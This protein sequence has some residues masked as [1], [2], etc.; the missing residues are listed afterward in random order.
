[1]VPRAKKV[2]RKPGAGPLTSDIRSQPVEVGRTEG[3]PM[4][5]CC[6]CRQ[7]AET[8]CYL[9]GSPACSRH[10]HSVVIGPSDD[11]L[12]FLLCLTCFELWMGERASDRPAPGSSS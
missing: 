6:F 4:T 7:H 2:E 8:R 3:P 9:C 11:R 10:T 12:I 5:D 1:M